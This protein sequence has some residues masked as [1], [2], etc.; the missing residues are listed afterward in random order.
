MA[1]I[2]AYVNHDIDDAV[3]AGV[4]DEAALPADAVALLGRSSSQ[5]I[6]AMVTDVVH[7]T[8]D[9]GLSEIRMG[10]D[11]LSAT[12]ELRSFLFEAVYENP[13]AT[14]EFQKTADVLGGIWE[15]LRARPDAY[16]DRDDHRRRRAGCRGTRLSGRDDRSI[17]RRALRGAVCAEVLGA[18]GVTT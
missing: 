17:C 16:L 2:I 9:G 12:L 3:R 18:L 4:L 15:K 13:S 7:R 1:D 14:A 11:V 8:L 5:R 10:D 6:N